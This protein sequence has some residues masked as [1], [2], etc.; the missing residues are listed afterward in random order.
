MAAG[1]QGM[2]P[3]GFSSAPS[4]FDSSIPRL[5]LMST[6]L[7]WTRKRIAIVVSMVTVARIGSCRFSFRVAFLAAIKKATKGSFS[8]AFDTV[9]Y[10]LTGTL[11]GSL[12]PSYIKNAPAEGEKGKQSGRKL[13]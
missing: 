10:R 12:R 7:L 11:A 4:S 5:G 3:P 9:L 13:G 1:C 6:S 2:F 8:A